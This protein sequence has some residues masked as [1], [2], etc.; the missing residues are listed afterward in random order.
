MLIK[1]ALVSAF[2]RKLERIIQTFYG[3][4]GHVRVAIIRTDTGEFKRHILKFRLL[5]FKEQFIE[6]YFIPTS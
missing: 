2:Q 3:S 5:P 4:Y 1:Y 6:N